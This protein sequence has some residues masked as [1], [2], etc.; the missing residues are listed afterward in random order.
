M[1]Y[2]YLSDGQ[3][4]ESQSTANREETRQDKTMKEGQTRLVQVWTAKSKT[5]VK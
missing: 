5:D 1:L 4:S 3:E 2:A